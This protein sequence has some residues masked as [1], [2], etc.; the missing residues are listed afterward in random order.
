M[1][2][3]LLLVQAAAWFSLGSSFFMQ[4]TLVTTTTDWQ[5]NLPAVLE[6]SAFNVLA[7]LALVAAFGFA[8]RRR[9]AV[10]CGFTTQGLS[11][12][13]ALSLYAHSRPPLMYLVMLYCIGLVI[14]LNYAQA[15]LATP[16]A[17][18]L[19]ERIDA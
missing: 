8:R 16:P 18:A 6:S 19:N 5:T 2:S 11:L 17:A 1:L 13:L 7:G 4:L 9:W 3:L 10:V 12:L 14:Y 15:Q